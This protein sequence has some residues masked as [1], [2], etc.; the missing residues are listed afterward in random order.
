M[1]EY[2]IEIITHN[3]GYAVIFFGLIIF[4]IFSLYRKSNKK[5]TVKVFFG[6]SVF[7]AVLEILFRIFDDIAETPDDIISA[8]LLFPFFMLGGLCQLITALFALI[9]LVHI[10]SCTVTYI[11]LTVRPHVRKESDDEQEL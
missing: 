8:I 6:C 2:C 11:I 4:E 3:I 9:T 1:L 5:Y 7:Y 10:I